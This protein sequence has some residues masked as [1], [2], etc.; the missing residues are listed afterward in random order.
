MN[1]AAD[2]RA[3]PMR[4]SQ[5][6]LALAAALG[7]PLRVALFSGN[8]DCVRD[9]A[10]QALNRLVA[11]L[12][13]RVRAEVRIYSPT[14]PRK[15][16][17]SVGEVRSVRSISIPGRPEYRIAL[18]F[19]RAAR[20]DFEDFA[21]DIVHLSAPDLLGRQAQNHARALGIPV[22]ASLHTRFETY[23][24]YYRL[25]LLRESVERYLDRFYGDCDRILC[26]TLPIARDMAARVGGERIA[27][28]GRG[29]D[30]ACFRPALR[31]PAFRSGLGYDATD[32]VPLFFGRLVLEK[33]LRVF[34]ETIGAVR[35]QGLAVRPLIVG[36]GP[37]RN[38]LA[39]RLPNATFMGHLSGEMLGRAVAS[40]DILINPSVTEAFGNVNLEA[41]A[42]GLAIV[43]ANVPSAS[44]LIADGR[45]GLLVPPKDV[46]AYAAAVAG[47]IR[48]PARRAALGAA[49]AEAAARFAWDDVLEDVARSYAGAL[50]IPLATPA[51]QAA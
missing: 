43:S 35:A 48:Q 4:L 38:W 47:L 15:A 2:L 36:E 22:V 16:F 5:S 39:E 44:A 8:Y 14:A 46:G 41:M 7:R 20:Q 12:L 10:N 18:G 13:H 27:I 33:G 21:P 42:S 32:M 28:W 9:G 3:D 45:T 40:A 29:I 25:S 30:P 1:H 34:A 24:D 31:D 17:A 23:L 51:A 50:H 37:A 6:R 49:A 11:Y 19:T 26:P